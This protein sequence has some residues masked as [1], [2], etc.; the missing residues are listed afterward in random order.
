VEAED[1]YER[2]GGT[3]TGGGT[4][5]GLGKLLTKAKVGLL[6]SIAPSV[7]IL[8]FFYVSEG[9]QFHPLQNISVIRYTLKRMTKYS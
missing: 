2:I 3:A 9:K 7:S 6:D 4:F 5:W 1:R 8:V